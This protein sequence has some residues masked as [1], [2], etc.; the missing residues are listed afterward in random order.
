MYLFLCP[1]FHGVCVVFLKYYLKNVSCFSEKKDPKAKLNQEKTTYCKSNGR[2]RV[3]SSLDSF[4]FSLSFTLCV[5]QCNQVIMALHG[6]LPYPALDSPIRLSPSLPLD[7]A[8]RNLHCIL[9]FCMF[10]WTGG[11]RMNKQIRRKSSSKSFRFHR[12]IF[13]H[14]T[15]S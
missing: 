9:L 11:R 15:V 13:H 14:N 10:C 5:M 12:S 1:I 4:S 8:G 6:L 3:I 2:H 7:E